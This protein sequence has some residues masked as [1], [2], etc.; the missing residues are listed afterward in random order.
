MRIDAHQHF[1]HYSPA[2]YA[3]IDESLAPLRR[4]FLPQ[5]V[6]PAMVHS[7][8]DASV[9]VQARQTLEETAFLLDLVDRN[10]YVVGVVGWVDLRAPTARD[11]I[12]RF[13]RHPRLV[14]LRHI[15]QGEPDDR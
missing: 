8:F 7:G 5:D 1:W 15:V 6:R 11:Q 2:E 10:P 14:G 3:W 12:A 9:A 13:A 4:D